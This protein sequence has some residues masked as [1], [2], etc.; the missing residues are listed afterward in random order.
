MRASSAAILGCVVAA[1]GC[2]SG[3]DREDEARYRDFDLVTRGALQLADAAKARAAAIDDAAS[4]EGWLQAWDDLLQPLLMARV[5]AAT[6]R[7]AA[8]PESLGE[9]DAIVRHL[10]RCCHA[11]ARAESGPRAPAPAGPA[12]PG[13]GA[14]GAPGKG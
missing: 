3:W 8:D 13:D 7:L 4:R 14:T 11:L 12:T 10:V 9:L 6:A 2:A 1:A 5:A